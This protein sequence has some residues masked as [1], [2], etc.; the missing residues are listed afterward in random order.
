MRWDTLAKL[1]NKELS[2]ILLR[3]RG[4]TRKKDIHEF[5]NPLPPQKI[6]PKSVGI[7]SVQLK[8][9]IGRIKKAL[10]SNEP[11]VI[12]GD[13]DADG[14]CSTAILWE[15]LNSLGVKAL[16]FIPRREK[17]GYGLSVEG[18]KAVE[19]D[20]LYKIGKNKGL[21]ITT[22]NGIVANSAVDHARKRGVDVII[23]DHHEKP[24]KLPKASAIIHTTKLCAAGI[25]Y[26]FSKE[27][28]EKTD[29][30]L[31]LATI[32]TV[33]DLMPLTGPNRSIVKFGL[34]ALNKTKRV[35]L[36][37]LFAAAGITKIT[38]YEIGF[39]IGPRL[40]ASGRI[41]SALTAL[42]LLCTK[43]K[44]KAIALAKTLDEVNRERQTMTEE[45]TAHALALTDGNKK[46]TDR[47][48]IAEHESYHQGVIGLIAGKL[49]EK[50]YLPA[51]VISKGE[52]VSKASARSIVG[53]NIIEAIRSCDSLLINAG[54]H[55]MAAGFSLE[56]AKISAFRKKIT[57][58]T[59]KSL[60]GKIPEK[61]LR[62]DSELD[63]T[64]I[65]LDFYKNI[66]RLSPFGIGN[67]EPVFS[68]RAEIVSLRRVGNSGKHLKLTVLP[69]N[70]DEKTFTLPL[71]AIAFNLGDLGTKLQTGDIISLAY[72]VTL[73]TFNGN[74][75][76]QLKVKDIHR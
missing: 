45:L 68:S 20:P 36:Q 44:S 10:K 22:D 60:A 14:I 65:D 61:T 25:T 57:A 70:R 34:E 5:L 42:R 48:I 40:N 9:A 12:Y 29:S 75:K 46:D 18:L 67:P 54:G 63:L 6:T 37:S 62:V 69:E 3:N 64:D 52:T 30:F 55:P 50:Y 1:E 4:L 59:K 11:V 49:V 13:Y 39:M 47:I 66:S 16:P 76:V 19:K 74:H 28:S 73:D 8:K 71:D 35:G 38:P 31:E 32:A 15:T 2:E 33:T 51:I 41:E 24:K 17:E 23:V 58:F 7:D 72:S 21:I 56:S 27:L 26:V 53:F 43:D